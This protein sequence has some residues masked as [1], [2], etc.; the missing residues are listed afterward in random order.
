MLGE[1]SSETVLQGFYS[2]A[3]SVMSNR[4]AQSSLPAGEELAKPMDSQVRQMCHFAKLFHRLL[5]TSK[6]HLALVA[7]RADN[8]I[9]WISCNPADTNHG[10]IS[11]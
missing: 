2:Q 9:H 3:P 8:L 5:F 6:S 4:P 7:Q 10:K 1:I 11:T